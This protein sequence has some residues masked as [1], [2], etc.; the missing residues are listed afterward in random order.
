VVERAVDPD[1]ANRYATAATF[2]DALSSALELT[3]VEPSTA[4]RT[5]RFVAAGVALSLTT[6]GAL[7]LGSL[8]SGFFNL[9]LGRSDFV[10]ETV[11]DWWVWGLK[12]HVGP[13]VIAVLVFAALAVLRVAG[14]AI[15][16]LC[17]AALARLRVI[18]RAQDLAGRLAL[19][20]A[21]G[22][23]SWVLLLSSAGLVLT[24][25]YF[26]PLIFALFTKVSM[27]SAE[28]HALLSPAFDAYQ[29]QY[30]Q[31]LSFLVTFA[32]IGW[33]RV[34]RLATA[35]R[36][37]VAV[38]MLAGGAAVTLLTLASLDVPYRLL[39]HNK[40][41]VVKWN[42][43]E[44][45]ALGERATQE[46]LFCP[47]LDPPRNRVLQKATASVTRLGRLESVFT[48]F[49]G[50]PHGVAVGRLASPD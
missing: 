3:R 21:P 35:A 39:V 34:L 11:W 47:E 13:A 45:Y 22:A 37:S 6:V 17:P 46:L 8:T 28:T 23:A 18:D 9:Q 42:D 44:C 38:G 36:Q 29:I 16:L 19:N 10:H 40:F 31:T 15:F 20:Q 24:W 49:G 30:F 27:A 1:L 26:S 5:R 2:L 4:A 48:K 32:A 41:E 25:W 12:A 7:A 50:T 43:T 14:R 33:Y